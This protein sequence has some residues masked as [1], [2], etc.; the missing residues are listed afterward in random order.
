MLARGPPAFPGRRCHA[1]LLC[2][3]VGSCRGGSPCPPA[4]SGIAQA[5]PGRPVALHPM[6]AAT[7]AFPRD[8]WSEDL[9]QGLEREIKELDKQV[10]E[11]RRA[12]ALAQAPEAKLQ[13]QKSIKALEKTR[14]TKRRE[15]LDA[16]DAIDV[17]R[18]E[19]IEGIERQLRQTTHIRSLFTVRWGVQ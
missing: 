11:V 18:D 7:A 3:E 10:R 14:N 15:L 17:K 12:A 8:R 16:Q 6:A 4:F 2:G 5:T 19:L 1:R 13:A 9:K